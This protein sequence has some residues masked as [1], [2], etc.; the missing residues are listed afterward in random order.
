MTTVVLG[1]CTYRRPDGLA[2]LLERV[3]AIAFD[4]TLAV[5]VVDNDPERSGLS[6]CR[7]LH[8]GYRWP[9]GCAVEPTPGISPA[10]NR[11]V[12]EALS[13]N[14]DFIAMLDDDEWPGAGWLSELL[15]VQAG[16]DADLVGGPIV[17][18]L[19]RP[20]EP[21]LSL[22][23]LYGV[24][25]ALPDGAPCLLYAAGNFITRSAVFRALMPAPF[26][27]RFAQT[28]GEDLAFFHRLARDGYRMAW[29]ANAVVYEAVPD[30]RLSLRWLC[31]RQLRIGAVNVAVQR[32]FAPGA[33]H[34]FVRLARTAALLIL[35]AC[36]L[37]LA[38]P[39]RGSRIRALLLCA[40]ACGKVI[41]HA[42]RT[43][44]EYR[45]AG[46]PAAASGRN[47]VLHT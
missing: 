16:S 38:L 29:A 33:G 43:V 26:D 14:P 7:Q 6:V 25:Q 31:R 10:R 11:V 45:R 34:E 46:G 41:G 2:R 28:G 18:S 19:E 3:A 40:R 8:R 42:G 37:A 23:G 21:W 1:V 4:G 24:D 9:L 22:A 47:P 15:A 30:A 12:A 20:R 36:R 32:M 35:S 13:L 44:V 39:R 5:M 17:A 27:P